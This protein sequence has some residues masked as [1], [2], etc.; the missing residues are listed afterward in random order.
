MILKRCA[1]IAFVLAAIVYN[2]RT[3]LALG[4]MS[5]TG[6]YC[7][8]YGISAYECE[9]DDVYGDAGYQVPCYSYGFYPSM[10]VYVGGYEGFTPGICKEQAFPEQVNWWVADFQCDMTDWNG[11]IY[12][13]S[14]GYFRCEWYNEACE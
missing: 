7:S 1:A 2:E 3:V 5:C 6:D 4:Y 14:I 13:S 9:W 10:S 11:M 12:E 8:D